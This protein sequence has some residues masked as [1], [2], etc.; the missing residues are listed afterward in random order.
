VKLLQEIDVHRYK[1]IVVLTG[2]GIS[3]ASGL[4]TYRGKDGLWNDPN[5]AKWSDIEGFTQD[6][7]G[8]WRFYGT[9]RRK[10]IEAKPNDAHFALAKFEQNL[11]EGKSFTLITQNVDGL[12]ARAGSTSVVELHGSI[13]VTRCSDESCSFKAFT[14]TKSYDDGAPVCPECGCFLRPDIVLFGEALPA[15]AEVATKRAFRDC[16]LFIAVGTSGNVSPAASFVQ[17]AK[18]AGAKT[19]LVNLEKMDPSGNFFD[20]QIEGKAEEI[21]P[22]ILI[23]NL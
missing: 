18:Y 20:L 16:D 13:L 14:D 1:S 12:H 11:S 3:V 7:H 19:V 10:S 22:K 15:R 8:S 23:G 6:P 21:L 4:P 5:T 2:A 17:W 9:L